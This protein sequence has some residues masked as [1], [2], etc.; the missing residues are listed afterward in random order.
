M[1]LGWGENSVSVLALRD[2]GNTLRDP[3]T[4]EPVLVVSSRVGQ[5]LTGLTQEQLASPLETMAQ[6]PIPGL[7]LIPY[8]AVGQ[9]GGML[10]GLRL[11]QVKIDGKNQKAVAAFA[12]AGLSGN[13]QALVA[14]QV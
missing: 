14:V 13:Y 7:R 4:G 3:I 10:L 2:S 6:R 1:P 8:Q 12:P 9:N 5:R 11:D